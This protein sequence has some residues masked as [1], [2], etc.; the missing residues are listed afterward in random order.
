M[1]T[2]RTKV[3]DKCF[4]FNVKKPIFHLNNHWKFVN[5]SQLIKD[6]FGLDMFISFHNVTNEWDKKAYLNSILFKINI[7]YLIIKSGYK[8]VKVR[9]FFF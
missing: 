1:M 3:K 6:C 7:S 4:F 2:I 5:C 9:L 8:T